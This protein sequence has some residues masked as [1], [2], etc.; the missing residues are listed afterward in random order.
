MRL[1]IDNQSK[2]IRFYLE[3]SRFVDKPEFCNA[4]LWRVAGIVVQCS[5]SMKPRV[6]NANLLIT[7][8]LDMCV[9][10][11]V[12]LNISSAQG[13]SVDLSVTITTGQSRMLDIIRT[14]GRLAAAQYGA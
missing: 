12:V 8:E 5:R 7:H 10:L 3:I 1:E 6:R 9:T 13:Q 2:L 14:P 4:R 11:L